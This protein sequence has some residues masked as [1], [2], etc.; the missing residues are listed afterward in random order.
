LEKND[1]VDESLEGETQIWNNIAANACEE[2]KERGGKRIEV[3]ERRGRRQ[4]V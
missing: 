3:V 1:D 4:S 2:F